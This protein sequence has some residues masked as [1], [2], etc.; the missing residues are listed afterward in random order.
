L[1]RA[2]IKALLRR[3]EKRRKKTEREER[4]KEERR[5]TRLSTSQNRKA[6]DDLNEKREDGEFGNTESHA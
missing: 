4:N 5:T 2:Y 3:E 1:K 6:L